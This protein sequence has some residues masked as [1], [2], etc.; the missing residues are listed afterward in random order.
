MGDPLDNYVCNSDATGT[1]TDQRSILIRSGQG[2]MA[3]V[4]VALVLLAI[5]W[6]LSNPS[7][8]HAR[9]A[10]VVMDSRTGQI[11][12]ARNADTKLYPAS[13]TKIMTLYMTFDGLKRGK[14]TMEQ[15][16]KVSKRAQGQT[17]TKL[18]LKRGETISVRNAILALV[19]KSANDAATVLAEAMAPS[20]ALFAQ[21]MTMKARQLGMRRTSFRN[22]S[23]L[24]NRR[25]RSTARDMALLGAAL[26]HEFPEYYHYF[27]KQKF[28]W[29]GKN[30]TNHNNLLKHYEGADGIKTGYIRASGF[31]LVA[32]AKRGNA[33]VIGVVFGGKTARSRDRHMATLLDKGFKKLRASRHQA[34]PKPRVKPLKVALGMPHRTQ[35]A[36]LQLASATFQ[37]AKP[38]TSIKRDWGLQIGAYSRPATAR[39]QLHKAVSIASDL[40]NSRRL[41]VEKVR[42]NNLPLFRAQMLGFTEGEARA[43]CQI[44]TKRNLSCI[45][46][47]PNGKALLRVAHS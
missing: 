8:A 7:T 20:E 46:V 5:F 1:Q 39:D 40:L 22:A 11:L 9:Y 12:H 16:L 41:N 35:N 37:P 3:M 21:K 24:P 42:Y 18:G 34:L 23:G 27:S 28:V 47:T 13:L 26:I 6:F 2:W 38:A 29:K 14:L 15:K 17:P 10:S 43:A 44:L 31:N 45:V 25:Q 32:S 30:L 4:T 33:R 19:T 36:K